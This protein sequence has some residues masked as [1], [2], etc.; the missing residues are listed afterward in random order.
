MTIQ[1]KICGITTP[2]TLDAAIKGGASHIGFMFFEKSPRHLDFEKAAALAARLPS[3][4]RK[5]GVFAEQDSIYFDKAI[6][7]AGLH[8]LQLHATDPQ[9]AAAERQR[10][11]KGIWGVVPV[12]TAADLRRA[13]EWKGAA[14]RILYDA[15]TP[16]DASLPGGLGLRFDWTLLTSLDHPLPWGL[17]GGLNPSNVAEA[18]RITGAPLVDVSSGVEVKPGQKDVDKIAA[19]LK[20]ASL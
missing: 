10:T 19:F 15:K 11:G 4:I 9:Q 14:D 3:H 1:T 18:I 8:I 7:A 2:E 13:E 5:V 6:H 20:A 16:A 12:K 17:A